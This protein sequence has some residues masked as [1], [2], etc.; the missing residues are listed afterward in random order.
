MSQVMITIGQNI[1]DKPMSENQWTLFKLE[2]SSLFSELFV[3]AEFQ[4]QWGEIKEISQLFIG[5]P[6]LEPNELERQLALIALRFNQ[7]AIG[8]IV[9]ARN[10]SLV[11]KAA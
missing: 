5:I 7:D 1:K 8:L 4:G 6:N 10:D 9:N 2:I 11:Y 3:N